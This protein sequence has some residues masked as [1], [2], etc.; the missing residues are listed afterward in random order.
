MVVDEYVKSA[1]PVGS[2]HVAQS[3][4]LS[5]SPATIRN[6]MSVLE[7]EGYLTQPHVSAGRIP[8]D[9]GYRYYVDRIAAGKHLD[10]V[11]SHLVRDFFERTTG[12]IEELLH[13]T[14]KVLS[15]LTNCTSVVTTPPP[16]TAVIRHVQLISLTSA[17]GMVVLVVANGA[18][19]KELFELPSDFGDSEEEEEQL[20]THASNL[21]TRELKGRQLDDAVSLVDSGNPEVDRLARRGLDT[22]LRMVAISDDELFVNEASKVANSFV[23]VEQV[24]KILETLEQQILVVSL[25]KSIVERGQ[26]VSIGNENGVESLADCALVIAPYEFEGRRVGSIGVIG[27]TRMNYPLALAAVQQVSR[28][29]GKHLVEG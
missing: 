17:L 7:Q 9:K 15:I 25:M 21:L 26:L 5:A 3:P 6:D 24:S 18:I 27:P 11:S 22:V 8:T 4:E 2:A 14:S 13:E 28:G 23:A 10:Q 16:K 20:F 29:I 12:E 19:V 1:E